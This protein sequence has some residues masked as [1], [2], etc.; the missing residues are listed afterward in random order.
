[1]AASYSTLLK[2]CTLWSILL[3]CFQFLTVASSTPVGVRSRWITEEASGRRVKLGS[4]VNWVGHLQAGLPEGLNQQP[5]SSIATNITSL[6]FN[7][8]RLTYSIHMLTRPHYTS[9]AVG[10][11][12]ESLN[13]TVQAQAIELHNP[14]LLLL[15]HL[16]AYKR[17]VDELAVHGVMVV[18]ENH[19]SNEQWNGRYFNPMEWLR[20]LA[21]MVTYFRHTPNVVAMSLRKE[22]RGDNSTPAM[23]SKYMHSGVAVV[24]RANPN[25]LVILD[26]DIDIDTDLTLPNM[27]V[28]RKVSS[29]HLNP[30]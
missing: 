2:L 22:V 12:F 13:L 19:V 10:R 28:F 17:V 8:V 3:L 1:M 6:G 25:V 21:R 16:Q 24:H 29:E 4:C 7:C 9:S 14:G 11:T 27:R 20:G 30:A 18:L 5:I 26:I 23:W 15:T